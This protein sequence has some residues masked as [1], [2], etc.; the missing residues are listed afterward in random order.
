MSKLFA[1]NLRDRRF[2]QVEKRRIL[3]YRKKAVTLF[4]Y[5]MRW[6]KRTD[7]GEK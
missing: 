6:N 5:T 2:L 4:L 3:P 7:F 1:H